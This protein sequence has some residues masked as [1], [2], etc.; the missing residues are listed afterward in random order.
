[1]SL[2]YH[3][4]EEKKSDWLAVD[5]KYDRTEAAVNETVKATATVRSLR[6]EPAPMVMLELP[7]PPG[8][9]P[10]DDAF[11]DL[12]RK[13]RI[14]RYQAEPGRVLLYLTELRRDQPL[15][16]TYALRPTLP[17]KA[18]AAGARA[19]EYYAPER[20]ATSPPTRLT[21]KGN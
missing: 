11:A 18:T 8:F 15:T 3:V 19:Y 16:V 14:A 9:Q 6:D 12:V 4:K 7:L 1:M 2:R 17:V 13:Q 20:E 21:V 10:A 5:L